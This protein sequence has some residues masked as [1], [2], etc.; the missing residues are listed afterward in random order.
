MNNV[1]KGYVLC[2]I[3]DIPYL[4]F[5]KKC[6]SVDCLL[7]NETVNKILFFQKNILIILIKI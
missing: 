6:Q 1:K 7:C 2:K 4:N 3:Y 5:F